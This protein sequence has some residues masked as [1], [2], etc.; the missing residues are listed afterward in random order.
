MSDKY[1]NYTTEQ[2]EFSHDLQN[3]VEKMQEM[4]QNLGTIDGATPIGFSFT[5]LTQDEETN[6]TTALA[7][8]WLG[9]PLDD[10]ANSRAEIMA[11]AFSLSCAH[12]HALDRAV[13]EAIEEAYEDSAPLKVLC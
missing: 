5:V 11:D 7:H 8:A 3:L 2:M 13:A 4:V 10:E 1:G 6:H 12:T 9:P